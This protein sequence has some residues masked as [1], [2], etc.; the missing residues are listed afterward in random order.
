MDNIKLLR[1]KS[2]AGMVDCKKALDEAGGDIEKAIEILRKKGISKAAKRSDREANEGIVKAMVGGD[3]KKGFM[4]EVNSETDFVS[5]ND[6]FR[7]FAEEVLLTIGEKEPAGM[8]ELMALSLA[9]GRSVEDNM[10]N[11]SGVIGEKISIKRFTV[12]HGETVAAYVHPGDRI[13]VLV[14]LSV[15]GRDDLAKDLAMHI[16]AANPPYVS[17]EEVPEEIVAKEKEI[18]AEHLRKEG[19]TEEIIEKIMAGK[20]AKFHEE[21]CL[22]KQDYIKDDKKKVEEVLGGAKINAFARFML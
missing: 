15:A 3:A 17:P 4:V 1:E 6:S 2:G 20:I 12:L 19:K 13:G 5:R 10:Q 16:A 18:Y 7:A 11:M 21:V 22:L 14:S 8:A 9:D